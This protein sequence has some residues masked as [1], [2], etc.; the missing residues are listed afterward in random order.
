MADEL[1]P[2]TLGETLKQLE[3]DAKDAS[4]T[5]KE[6]SSITRDLSTQTSAYIRAQN[7]ISSAIG[8]L[9]APILSSIAN[10]ITNNRIN[11]QQIV[12]EQQRLAQI[13]SEI[14][15][16]DAE[17]AL[18]EQKYAAIQ[19]EIS[20]LNA[21]VEEAQ[22]QRKLALME[23]DAQTSQINQ[24]NEL[25]EQRKEY[26]QRLKAEG[27]SASEIQ[28]AEEQ[29]KEASK[30]LKEAYRVG[31]QIT[32]VLIS[33]GEQLEQAENERTSK[34]GQ[35]NNKLE[36]QKDQLDKSK[37]EESRLAAA[38]KAKAEELEE[39]EIKK[40]RDKLLDFVK[41]MNGLT[42][43]VR[44]TQQAFGVAA[45]QA[46][47]LN[48]G[49]EIQSA[50]S[51]FSL[52]AKVSGEEIRGA[53]SAFQ[54]EFGGVITPEA[55]KDIAVQAKDLGVT[56]QQLAVARRQFMTAT[57]GNVGAAAAQQD[58]FISE[59]QK[60]GLTSKDALNA[61]AQNS[62]IF[63]R[64][65]T[66]F[67]A[68]FARAAADAKKIGV[69]LGKID[70]I[71][72]NIIGDFE[73][74]LEKT[75]ELGAMGFGFDSQRMAE[76]AESGDT[77]ALMN[78]L[79]SQLAAQG[80]DLT[81]LRRSE[82]LALSQAFGVPMAELQR[83]AQ[84]QTDGSGEQLT[85][86]EK[87]TTFLSRLV[88]LVEKFSGVLSII[89][90]L[91][92]G[93]LYAATLRTAI[94]TT[95]MATG[96]S[97][98][99][100][101]GLFGGGGAAAGA[102][103]A[104]ETGTTVATSGVQ[105][106]STGVSN[107]GGGAANMLKI[108]VSMVALAAS[109]Y[110]LGKALL[111]FNDINWE[112]LAKMGTVIG[113]LGAVI[114]FAGPLIAAGLMPLYP[115]IPVIGL[116]TLALLGVGASL[117]LAAPAFEA[118]GNI[119]TAVL[120]GV[121]GI[122]TSVGGVLV[123]MFSQLKEMSPMQLIALGGSLYVMSGGLMALGLTG[124]GA[125]VG[126]GLAAFAVGRLVSK[127]G[128]MSLLAES[129]GKLATNLNALSNVNTAQLKEVRNALPTAATAIQTAAVASATTPKPTTPAAETP[130]PKIDFSSLEKKL[131]GVVTAIGRMRV[132]LDGHKVGRVI[133]TNASTTSQVGVFS[134]S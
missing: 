77:G 124:L 92:G 115:A 106:A 61:I 75:A 89:A 40:V 112:S 118:F 101:K 22:L 73:G 17:L 14:G 8:Q 130:Q 74:F 16:N 24:L 95:R 103:T 70:Q 79:R 55:A 126:I 99:G 66:R 7:S 19:G 23:S 47:K 46:L 45:G 1:G 125:S 43:S 57:M 108:G 117:R 48:I 21:N 82:Q 110:I 123:G 59:F 30:E 32:D 116:L 88:N 50:L 44:K 80:K 100:L 93:S 49:T 85:A 53:I 127:A 35:L 91:I 97:F 37:A 67:A 134:T 105:Q 65:G 96:G 20:T 111:L 72:D 42:D 39:L 86:Q 4:T 87:A 132:E 119:I 3:R 6:V 29:R 98:G 33:A 60:K 71:G 109:M 84:T 56:T 121:A 128:A 54:E 18:R 62:E 68:S 94:N 120:S 83:L 69:D 51:Y 104:A 78:E 25:V 28:I 64:N 63:A 133:A 107:F 13:Q 38:E 76:V 15:K 102:K 41:V 90:G 129:A 113:V 2:K 34:L 26:V 12:L 11:T 10:L 27:A 114:A 122:I 36:E 31:T 81:N 9:K 58:K 131:D 5:Y 52:S